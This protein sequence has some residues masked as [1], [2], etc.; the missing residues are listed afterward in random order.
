MTSPR[1]LVLMRHA[2]A[3]SHADADERR[4]LAPA[5]RRQASA[6]GAAMAADG[7][8]LDAALVSSAAR[9]RQTWELL[10]HELPDA[11]DAEIRQD[12]YEATPHSV[13]EV[14]RR[15][16]DAVGTLLVVGHEPVVSS[17]AL[18]LAGPG[19]SHLHDVRAGV[20]TATRCVLTVP[21]GWAELAPRS[22]VLDAVVRP[23]AD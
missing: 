19:S 8:R 1:T 18:L 2:K 12:L 22:A 14:L 11:P 5:G 20:P 23:S 10:A 16:D 7:L 9:T 6:A 21:S 15:V 4:V 3:E 17:L 13:L